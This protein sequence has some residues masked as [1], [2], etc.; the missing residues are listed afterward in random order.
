M[1][2]LQFGS[3]QPNVKSIFYPANTVKEIPIQTLLTPSK[4]LICENLHKNMACESC[5][6]LVMNALDELGIS[7]F[8]VEL[9]EIETKEELSDLEKESEYHNQ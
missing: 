9:G 2:S 6:I 4:E 7:P 5:K 3:Y 8:K 1:A